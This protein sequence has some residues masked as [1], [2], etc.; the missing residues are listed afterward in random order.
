MI[1]MRDKKIY[2]LDSGKR[3]M[4]KD[5]DIETR[6][7]LELVDWLRQVADRCHANAVTCTCVRAASCTTC[8]GVGGATDALLFVLALLA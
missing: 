2:K 1:A 6:Y 4:E 7:Y 3:I 8:A 5:C